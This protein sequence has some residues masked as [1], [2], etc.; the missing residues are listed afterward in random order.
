MEDGQ[1]FIT[2]TLLR[3][4]AIMQSRNL[5]T[6]EVLRWAMQLCDIL[7][8][9]HSLTPSI[10]HRDVEPSNIILT[11]DDRICL[12]DFGSAKIYIPERARVKTL[13][14]PAALKHTEITDPQMALLNIPAGT[15]TRS[16]QYSLAAT[17]YALLTG[18]PPL[19]SRERVAGKPELAPIR[20]T[21][22]SP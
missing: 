14:R 19:D 5:S 13:P 22:F 16:D 7:S 10:I 4:I 3:S 15:D 18:A 8:H 21:E 11:S 12:V 1:Q 9:L 17:L 6:E 2:W 20:P